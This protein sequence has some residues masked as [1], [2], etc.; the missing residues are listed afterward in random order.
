MH[1]QEA[2]KLNKQL[3]NAATLCSKM[4][5]MHRHKEM[6]MKNGVG[7]WH[8]HKAHTSTSCSFAYLS[9]LCV[10]RFLSLLASVTDTWIFVTYRHKATSAPITPIHF[11]PRCTY[12]VI[13][14]QFIPC[15]ASCSCVHW[16]RHARLSLTF[17][18]TPSS[19]YLCPPISSRV[20]IAS[21]LIPFTQRHAASTWIR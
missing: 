10:T 18:C 11:T 17:H 15:H 12:H 3:P 8:S 2:E 14:S 9:L 16:L 21:I 1:H 19:I 7:T 6:N 4:T 13:S 5:Q 20:P